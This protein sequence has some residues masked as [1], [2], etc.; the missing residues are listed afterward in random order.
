VT[1]SNAGT[2][3]GI[4]SLASNGVNAYGV[5]GVASAGESE[6]I[7]NGI[8]GYFAADNSNNQNPTNR[9]SVQLK[10]GTEGLNKV[11]TCVTSDGKANW[12][13]PID[14]LQIAL[15]SQVFS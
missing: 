13:T 14:D 9:Y 10:D 12:V 2:T 15:I 3:S 6:S 4:Y 5:Y 7:T 8:G 11:L 1:S